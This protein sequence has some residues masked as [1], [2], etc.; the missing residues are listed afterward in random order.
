VR[1]ES[2]ETLVTRPGF[3]IEQILSGT[4][5]ESVEYRQDHDEW[6]VVLTGGAT[7]TVAGATVQLEAGE[8][9]YLPRTVPHR[10]EATAPGTSWLAVRGPTEATQ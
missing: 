2:V 10:L 7:L 3:S 8:W 1:G 9:L 5:D 6:V 4:L